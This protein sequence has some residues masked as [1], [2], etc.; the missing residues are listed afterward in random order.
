MKNSFVYNYVIQVDVWSVGCL[1]AELLRRKPFL[2]GGDSENLFL[3]FYKVLLAR[4]QIEL[5]I[6]F[7]GTP[8]EEE[9][10][11]IPRD[12]SRKLLRS[13]PKKKGKP[14]ETFFKTTNPQG[15]FNQF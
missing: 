12:K 5:I 3:W 14:F 10:N 11:N 13:L 15:F 6:D 2:P 7:L 8:P 4:N 1:F 9:I